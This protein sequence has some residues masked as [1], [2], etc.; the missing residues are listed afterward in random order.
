VEIVFSPVDKNMHIPL[1]N[2]EIGPMSELF[3]ANFSTNFRISDSKSLVSR[4]RPSTRNG[5]LQAWEN[6]IHIGKGNK[7][8][9]KKDAPAEAGSEAAKF[10]HIYSTQH[11]R[12]AM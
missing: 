9:T 10:A 11:L 1:D 4:L 8:H 3:D 5:W 6:C 12:P 2:L 7:T